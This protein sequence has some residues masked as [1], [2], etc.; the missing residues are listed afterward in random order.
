M[1]L[2][3]HNEGQGET[4]SSNADNEG[5]GMLPTS[6]IISVMCPALGIASLN[7]APHHQTGAD[8]VEGEAPAEGPCTAHQ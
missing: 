5:L 6:G 2:Q 8:A 4:Q 3:F 7:H 1:G